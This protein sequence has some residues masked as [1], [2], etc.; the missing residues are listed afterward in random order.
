MADTDKDILK[1]EKEAQKAAKKA[2]QERIKQS[3]PKKDGTFFSRTGNSVKKFWKDFT[4]TVKKIVWPARAQVLKSSAIV[5]ASIVVVGL[6]IF[7]FDRGLNALFSLGED[8]AEN[9]GSAYS[10]TEPA[11]E[12][13]TSADEKTTSADEKT[14][15]EDEKGS[16]AENTEGEETSSDETSSDEAEGENT[17]AVS[18]ESSDEN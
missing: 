4:G 9:L 2:K 10:T 3:K 11:D 1:A 18:E 8:L 16:D 15:G 14:T 6:V 5:L 7:G 17:D 13:S 12:K